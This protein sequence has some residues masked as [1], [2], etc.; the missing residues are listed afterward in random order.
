L[1]LRKIKI[2]RRW[3]AMIKVMMGEKGAGKTK[4][5]I[6]MVNNAVNVEM[7]K[8]VCINKGNRFMYDLPH[9][10]RLINTEDF[11]VSNTDA[12]LGFVQRVIPNAYDV[13]HIFIDSLLKI[14]K[15]DMDEAAAFLDSI[16]KIGERYNVKFTITISGDSAIAS[17][18]VRKYFIEF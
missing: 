17:D 9:S 4:V 8:V 2:K 16:S 13:T 5:L 18:G 12:F 10:V 6:N 3:V 15:A 14:I 7:G 11:N 1:E